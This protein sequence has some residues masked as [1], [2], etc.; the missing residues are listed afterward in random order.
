MILSYFLLVK[1]NNLRLSLSD[2][3]IENLGAVPTMDFVLIGL[4]SLRGLRGLDPNFGKIPY[5][6]LSYFRGAPTR[7]CFSEVREW[8]DRTTSNMARTFQ[9][10]ITAR[11]AREG[12]FILFLSQS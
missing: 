1:S 10:H 5:P 9:Q 3:K 12:N 2:I 11:F 4:Q 6:L 7:E 8:A